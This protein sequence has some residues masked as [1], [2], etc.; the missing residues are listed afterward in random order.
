M[1]GVIINGKNFIAKRMNKVLK[2]KLND[3]KIADLTKKLNIIG[4]F[5]LQF[6]K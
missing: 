6:K 4:S 1:K 2:D 5:K 3:N